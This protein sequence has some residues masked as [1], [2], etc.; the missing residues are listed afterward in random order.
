MQQGMVLLEEGVT[1]RMLV[2]QTSGCGVMKRVKDGPAADVLTPDQPEV[3]TYA[4]MLLM[5]DL[6]PI[7]GARYRT[8]DVGLTQVDWVSDGTTW[9]NITPIL[10]TGSP[11]GVITAPIG[12]W[13]INTSGGAATTLYIKEAAAGATG[14]VAK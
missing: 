2:K 10:V 12:C 9:R 13:A 14:W 6:T 11:L 4:Q 8:I 3:G 5:L 1:G 7:V